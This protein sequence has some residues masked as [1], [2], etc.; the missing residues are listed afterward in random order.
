MDKSYDA[1]T[2]RFR[3][4]EDL[5]EFAKLVGSPHLAYKHPIMERNKK[6]FV[7][8]ANNRGLFDE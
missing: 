4:Q 2:I 3:N 5:E 8:R 7:Y 6:K 1:I